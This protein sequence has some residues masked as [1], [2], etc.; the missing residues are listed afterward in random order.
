MEL[1]L[2]REGVQY[3]LGV[4]LENHSTAFSQVILHN[5]G[6]EHASQVS[7]AGFSSLSDAQ[8]MREK[9]QGHF[10]R[11]CIYEMTIKRLDGEQVEKA[12]NLGS[13]N[14]KVCK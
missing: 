5:E 10:R 11:L 6:L 1:R 14:K 7:V 3:V 2:E 12:E 8:R 9:L 4:P 13:E